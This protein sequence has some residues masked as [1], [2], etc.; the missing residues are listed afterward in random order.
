MLVSR[1]DL[2]FLNAARATRRASRQ[3][4]PR[5]YVISRLKREENRRLDRIM[6][7]EIRRVQGLCTIADSWRFKMWISCVMDDR[8][9]LSG[10]RS[11]EEHR[12]RHVSR[13][14]ADYE[15]EL[16]EEA[17]LEAGIAII[18]TFGHPASIPSGAGLGR[19]IARR[20]SP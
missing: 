7:Y 2:A 14:L 1:P 12:L 13:E 4:P 5:T 11:K 20:I 19:E 16:E 15:R 9:R 6:K 10:K 8:F 18:N 17:R 3:K